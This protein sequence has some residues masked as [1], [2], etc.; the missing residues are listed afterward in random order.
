M[1]EGCST[2][3]GAISPEEPP[4]GRRKSSVKPGGK[5]VEGQLRRETE[6]AQHLQ[7]GQDEATLR[8]RSHK[9]T[10]DPRGSTPELLESRNQTAAG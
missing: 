3:G 5:W 9:A 7:E 2:P 6:S 4:R 1:T 8:Y 10:A